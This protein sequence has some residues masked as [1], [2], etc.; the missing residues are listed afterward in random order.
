MSL[1]DELEIIDEKKIVKKKLEKLEQEFT[2]DH[3]IK[4]LEPMEEDKTNNKNIQVNNTPTNIV[5]E[6][7]K[8]DLKD[9]IK[10]EL[11]I[12]KNVSMLKPVEPVLELVV[13]NTQTDQVYSKWMKAHYNED[14]QKYIL[15]ITKN[16]RTLPNDDL[17]KIKRILTRVRRYIKFEY[18]VLNTWTIMLSLF[19]IALGL[20]SSGLTSHSE[21]HRNYIYY[22]YTID[23]VISFVSAVIAVISNKKSEKQ[24]RSENIFKVLGTIA[25]FSAV[26]QKYTY[27]YLFNIEKE[28]QDNIVDS[29]EIELTID[30][31]RNLE[32][33]YE[34][35]IR[36]YHEQKAHFTQKE[37]VLSKNEYL[38]SKSCLN[39]LFF[40][41]F[42]DKTR[43][44][45]SKRQV[46][47]QIK[48]QVAEDAERLKTLKEQRD[49]MDK[50]K[51][52][53]KLRKVGE[54]LH[55][56]N[57]SLLETEIDNVKH[58]LRKNKIEINRLQESIYY[59]D[60]Y[61]SDDDRYDYE[62]IEGQCCGCRCGGM[63]GYCFKCLNCFY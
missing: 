53:T 62:N 31:L 56:K 24:E 21:K 4:E 41:C 45:K 20:I 60:D 32:E 46:I 8:K 26:Y 40:M 37:R 28:I 25:E 63:C 9:E 57:K 50:E 13:K 23:S 35:I 44:K 17:I 49:E 5:I 15:Q 6:K 29:I 39:V 30:Q 7:L 3:K 58:R 54:K 27:K 55:I 11:N 14:D 59:G 18:D 43:V 1:Q 52:K 61:E 19:I 34:R 33:R 38:Y 36:E 16:Y 12:Q 47:E 42:I 10:N 22:I 51:T 2:K 48:E